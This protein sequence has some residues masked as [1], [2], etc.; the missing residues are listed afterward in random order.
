MD[1]RFKDRVGWLENDEGHH[2]TSATASLRNVNKNNAPLMTLLESSK[3]VLRG[4]GIKIKLIP[5]SR[6]LHQLYDRQKKSLPALQR[7]SNGG[8]VS[9]L[10]YVLIFS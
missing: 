4:L 3:I 8:L 6:K 7:K 9:T 2:G 5:E 1:P 10:E